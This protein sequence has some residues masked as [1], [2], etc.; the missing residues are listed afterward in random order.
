MVR[1]PCSLILS[2]EAAP[3]LQYGHGLLGS[4]SEA[5]TGHLSQLANDGGY[6]VVATD[7][8]GMSEKDRGA[9]TL[10][11]AQ[12]SSN[13][14]F[15]PERSVQ[16]F[17]E[18]MAVLHV[19]MKG[20][21]EDEL[22]VFEG[23]NLIDPSR[24]YYYG[25][26]QGGI[27]GGAYLALSKDLTK[28]VLGVPGAPYAL[29]LPRSYDFQPFFDVMT[30]KFDNAHDIELVMA[31]FQ[32]VW[33]PAEAAGW[34]KDMNEAPAADNTP[35]DVLLQVAIG[36][37][38]VSSLGAHVM[39]RAYGART[40]A[41]ETRPIWGIEEAEGGFTGSA[42]VEWFYPDGAVE[43]VENLPPDDDLDTHECPRR[44]AA[45]QQQIRDF[46]DLG[47][48]NQHCDGVCEGIRQ[49]FCD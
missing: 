2:P 39:A 23:T 26:S 6:V 46:F 25:I 45:A 3:I 35:K 19:A 36:D 13:F 16:G 18:F 24:R 40:V 41:P 14:A 9:I 28:G 11:V 49:G 10:M 15:V 42:I 29:L 22:L 30:A 34:L 21:V 17:V 43:P 37:A 31:L 48:V 4:M 47:V 5:K 1:I 27:L 8:K 20:L 12:D 38:Q 7:W 32:Q 33:D 44:E